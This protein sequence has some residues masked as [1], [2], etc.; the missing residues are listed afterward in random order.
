MA[1]ALS[2]GQQATVRALMAAKLHQNGAVSPNRAAST[3]PATAPS[4]S[5]P[6]PNSA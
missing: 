2:T 5:E 3:P 1:R 4:D 6:N